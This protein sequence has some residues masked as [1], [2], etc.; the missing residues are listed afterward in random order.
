MKPSAKKGPL[1]RTWFWPS[2][3]QIDNHLDIIRGELLALNTEF[4]RSHIES[5]LYNSS[6]VEKLYRKV[7]GHIKIKS[8]VG[9]KKIRLGRN[10]DGGY[11]MVDNLD[12]IDTAYSLGIFDDV[13]WDLEM[14]NRDIPVIQYDC[15]IDR[16]PVEH[17]HFTFYKKRIAGVRSPDLGLESIEGIV[18][19]HKHH[20][21]KLI[22]KMD[23]EGSEWDVLDA[24]HEN[25]LKLFDQVLLEVHDFRR[26]PEYEFRERA[27]RV[28]KK[29]NLSH[30]PVHVHANNIA[31]VVKLVDFYFS[32]ALEL[33]YVR[34][35]NYSFT[36]CNEVFPGPLDR[37][38]NSNLPDIFLG[39]F[40][41][42]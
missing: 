38:N 41:F 31:R 24:I 33:T 8:I 14:A 3:K 2:K 1:W 13:S 25:T 39:N 30:T 40:E 20:G 26:I 15:S 34:T 28:F 19:S 35:D 7:F 27:I 32:D 17:R 10:A 36:E 4:C 6:A 11:I 42:D 5:I 23:I 16:P 12:D 18:D 29:L 22:L 37:P 9:F 21:K